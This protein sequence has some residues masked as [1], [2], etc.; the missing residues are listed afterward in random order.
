MM[1]ITRSI[2][3]AIMGYMIGLAPVLA[4]DYILA[5]QAKEYEGY[6]AKVCGIVKSL[7]KTSKSTFIYF[8][9]QYPH[10]LFYAVIWSD[11]EAQINQEIPFSSLM[12][13]EVC[14]TG[15]ID[16]FENIPLIIVDKADQLELISE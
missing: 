2:T 3:I 8:D 11:K 14:V 7:E 1:K 10:K 12:E 13:K 4:S 15:L 6:P 16:S 5:T 9:D